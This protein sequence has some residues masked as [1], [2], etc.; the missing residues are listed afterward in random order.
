MTVDDG[1]GD[2]TLWQVLIVEDDPTIATIYKRTIAGMSSLEVAGTVTRGEDALQFLRHRQCDLMLLD[3]KLAGMNGI[4]LLH[5]LRGDGHGVEVIALTATRTS[6]AVRAVIQRGAIDY[7]VKPFTVERLRQSLGLFL[8]R[9]NALRDEQLDQEAVD[10]VCASG[11]VPRR[12]L[13]KGLTQEGVAR[14][15]RVLDAQT[16]AVCSA[17][18]ATAAGLARVTAR[19]YLEYLVT[20]DQ[21]SVEAAPAGPGRPR[22]LYSPAI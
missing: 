11:R 19:R 8:N 9:A 10:R 12:W 5:Q 16:R 14:V 20:I 7:V 1:G 4:R 22:K 15:R 3:L 6:A 21:A 17:E 18:V 2:G 13:P